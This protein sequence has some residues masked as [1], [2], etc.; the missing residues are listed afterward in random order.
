MFGENQLM[1]AYVLFLLS[2]IASPILLIIAKK[3][4]VGIAQVAL[5]STLVY[6]FV[7]DVASMGYYANNFILFN[8]L[9]IVC[10]IVTLY[11]VNTYIRYK[12]Q[13]LNLNEED[14]QEHEVEVEHQETKESNPFIFVKEQL[15][16]NEHVS[17]LTEGTN[18]RKENFLQAVRERTGIEL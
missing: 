8:G 17:L 11:A 12:K 7:S 1:V 15:M 5:I 2:S 4:I 9:I 13:N 16:G 10:T 6:F 14:L 3:T 18:Q